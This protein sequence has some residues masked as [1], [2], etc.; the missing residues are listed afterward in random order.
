MEDGG[1]SMRNE[2]HCFCITGSPATMIFKIVATTGPELNAFLFV[3]MIHGTIIY[4]LA[5]RKVI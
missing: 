4:S 2:K 5:D 3:T 1:T